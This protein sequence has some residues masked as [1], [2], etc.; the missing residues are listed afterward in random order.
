MTTRQILNQT[1]RMRAP[2]KAVRTPM[3]A[4][5]AAVRRYI[6]SEGVAHRVQL[7]GWAGCAGRGFGH[8]SGRSAIGVCEQFGEEVLDSPA[9]LVNDGS[10]LLDGQP[11]GV[12]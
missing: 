11:G 5:M 9:D 1:T 3:A 7:E 4:T 8:R 6:Q 12:F 2:V 10:Y